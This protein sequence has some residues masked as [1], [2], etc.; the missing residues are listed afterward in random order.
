[1]EQAVQIRNVVAIPLWYKNVHIRVCVS[2]IDMSDLVSVNK[3]RL[4]S[5]TVTL[6]PSTST[7]A[8]TTTTEPA[9]PPDVY[10]PGQGGH[11]CVDHPDCPLHVAHGLCTSDHYTLEQ[12]RD[13]CPKSCNLCLSPSA[14][15]ATG[16]PPSSPVSDANPHQANS[17]CVDHPE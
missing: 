14:D 8:T 5:Q 9:L 11:R 4:T 7:I 15:I 3:P 16:N 13:Y 12:K 1:M 17:K 2:Q 10:V 6:F